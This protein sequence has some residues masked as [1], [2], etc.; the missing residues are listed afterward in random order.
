MKAG[1]ADAL[2]AEE[3]Q[4]GARD[5]P[6][7]IGGNGLAPEGEGRG[8]SLRQGARR[9]ALARQGVKVG[10]RSLRAFLDTGKLPE[11]KPVGTKATDNPAD[12]PEAARRDESMPD[13]FRLWT[14]EIAL[15]AAGEL[16]YRRIVHGQ[17]CSGKGE[18]FSRE[19]PLDRRS[20]MFR[21]MEAQG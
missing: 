4:A 21:E 16:V 13:E 9:R 2:R 20:E 1:G 17:A 19:G 14:W 6:G 3:G 11:R 8:G 10:E 12:P 5:L 15:N 7:D 18:R